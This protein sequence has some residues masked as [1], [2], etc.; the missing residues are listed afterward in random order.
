ML[1]ESQELAAQGV[2]FRV[3]RPSGGS[4]VNQPTVT[5][6]RDQELEQISKGSLLL[7][8]TDFIMFH[9]ASSS[10]PFHMTCLTPKR[11]P[12]TSSG[13]DLRGSRTALVGPGSPPDVAGEHGPPRVDPGSS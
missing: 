2:V 13:R 8:V 3:S 10:Q 4:N 5:A 6:V 7:P 11:A 12:G 1:V 9:H